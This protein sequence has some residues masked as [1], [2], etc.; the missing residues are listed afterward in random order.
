MTVKLEVASRRV[1]FQDQAGS[2][3]GHTIAIGPKP[4]HRELDQ[5]ISTAGR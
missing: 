1:T 3:I 5:R 4:F 2:G